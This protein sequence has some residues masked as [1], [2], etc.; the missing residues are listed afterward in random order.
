MFSHL[1]DNLLAEPGVLIGISISSSSRLALAPLPSLIEGDNP[2]ISLARLAE[3]S[4]IRPVLA[5]CVRR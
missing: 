5:L 1:P 4:L 3:P 2:S